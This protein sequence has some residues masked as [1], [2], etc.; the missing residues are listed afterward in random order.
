VIDD[1]RLLCSVYRSSKKE[2]MYLYVR[3]GADLST[4]PEGLMKVFGLP[5]HALDLLLTAEKKLARADS[6]TVM[7]QI[8][9]QGFYLQMPPA[10]QEQPLPLARNP[11]DA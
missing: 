4:L 6:A 3:R 8:R 7:A 2:G 9:D 10:E 1:H 5:G 11:D